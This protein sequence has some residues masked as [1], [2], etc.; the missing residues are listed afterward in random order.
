LEKPVT[1]TL[2]SSLV[3]PT[4]QTPFHIDFDWWQK[5]E[6]DW[7]VY[8][9]SYLCPEHKVLFADWE[10]AEEVDWVDP[11]TAEVHSV[12][13]LQH[14]LM[15]HCARQEG[16]ITQQT[17]LVDSMFRMFLANGNTSLT[18]IEMAE[19]LGRQP[20]IILKTLSGGRVYKGLRPCLG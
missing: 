14:V 3:K 17:A 9:H 12:D 4:L 1:Q 15:T 10:F 5:N 13:G 18:P 16:F 19:H 2:H 8:L 11:E 20:I 7:R 6:R